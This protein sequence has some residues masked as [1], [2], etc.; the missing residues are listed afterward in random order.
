LARLRAGLTGGPL[1]ADA[2]LEP[3]PSAT[4]NPWKPVSST[5]RNVRLGHK[6]LVNIYGVSTSVTLHSIATGV[7]FACITTPGRALGSIRGSDAGA[8]ATMRPPRGVRKAIS[9]RSEGGSDRP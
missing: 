9:R 7:L 4:A 2:V 1:N 6:L 5:H 3:V 8:V